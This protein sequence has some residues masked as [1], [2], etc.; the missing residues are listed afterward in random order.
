VLSKRCRILLTRI[1]VFCAVSLRSVWSSH[2]RVTPHCTNAQSI[3]TSHTQVSFM[4]QCIVRVNSNI[5]IFTY[6]YLTVKK[7][8]GIN[9]HSR[10]S[11]QNP[12][13]TFPARINPFTPTTSY[14]NITVILTPIYDRKLTL[15]FCFFNPKSAIL[16]SFVTNVSC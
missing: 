16:T 7:I 13:R 11:I 4:L 1:A 5:S 3:R 9:S 6:Y 10:S 14:F 8:T 2:L 15:R 12:F